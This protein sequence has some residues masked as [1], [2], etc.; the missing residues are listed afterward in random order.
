MFSALLALA[1]GCLQPPPDVGGFTPVRAEDG[2]I[3]RLLTEVDR[4]SA[5]DPRGAARTIRE[6]VLPAARANA[7]ACAA[8]RPRHPRAQSLGS[9]LCS[10]LDERARRLERYASALDAGDLEAMLREVRAQREM[11][12]DRD[13]IESRFEAAERAPATRGCSRSP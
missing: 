11:E 7:S 8:V 5:R 10:L 3:I 1:W 13:R 6:L 2:R 12:R 4:D 9:D